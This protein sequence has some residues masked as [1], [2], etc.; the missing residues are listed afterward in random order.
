[1]IGRVVVTLRHRQLLHADA[2]KLDLAAVPEEAD[3]ATCPAQA[4][5][6]AQ[7]R[8]IGDRI[9]LRVQDLPPVQR[10]PHVPS[11]C[12]DLFR[13]PFADRLQRA[14]LRGHYLVDRAAELAPLLAAVAAPV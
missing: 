2:A 13:V 7:N 4:G 11:V 1:P 3:V 6:C 12:Q 9:E 8:R 10:Y 14:P 5:M